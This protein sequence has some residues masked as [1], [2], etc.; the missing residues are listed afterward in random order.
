MNPLVACDSLE[1]VRAQI[2]ALDQKIVAL[3][4]DRGI[5][6]S[7]AARFKRTTDEVRAPSRIEQVVC[8]VRAEATRCGAD[9]GIVEVT[10]RAMINAFIQMEMGE[11]TASGNARNSA[12][13]SNE[14][15]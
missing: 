14:Q 13:V 4:R 3:L 9:P 8:K 15:I 6:V 5:L 1:E 12:G 2:D 10:Y 7:Q 11:Y